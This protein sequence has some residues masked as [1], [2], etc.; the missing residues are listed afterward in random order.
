MFTMNKNKIILALFLFLM[1]ITLLPAQDNATGL[2]RQPDNLR[3]AL[4]MAQPNG[5]IKGEGQL[6]GDGQTPMALPGKVDLSQY[7]PR[8][9]TQ[10]SIGSCS[11]WSTVYYSKT[12]QENMERGWG[13]D[14]TD[15]MFNPMYTYNQIAQGRNEGT[16]IVDHMAM[17]VDQGCATIA[18]FPELYNLR[19]RPDQRAR[20]EAA[21]YKADS[22]ESLDVY[23]QATGKWNVD[24]NRVKTL[25]AAGYPVVVG[26]TL[27]ENFDNYQGGVY[28]R[29]QGGVTGGHAMCI[30]GYDDSIQAL[31]IVNSWGQDWGDNG[32]FYLSYNLFAE[33]A[34]WGAGVLYDHKTNTEQHAYPPAGL[35]ATQGTF[36][37]QIKLVWTAVT[38][39]KE[40]I[41][42]KSDNANGTLKEIARLKDAEFLDQPLPEGVHYI[43][44]VKSVSSSGK[45]S[46]FS[47]V[48][49]GWTGVSAAGN[50]PGIPG[51]LQFYFNGKAAVY[52]WDEV[53]NADGYYV[54]RWDAANE[55]WKIYGES[56]DGVF[57]DRKILK[58]KKEPVAYYIV[59]AWN[60]DGES[61]ATS[62]MTINTESPQ[63]VKPSAEKVVRSGSRDDRADYLKARTYE[64]DFYSPDYF[65]Y[66]YTMKQFQDFYEA[67]KKAFAEWK[68][69]EK[70]D[71]EAWK[72]KH[73]TV[74][75]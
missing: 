21:Q 37:G 2:E 57:L 50:E 28:N 56:R 19:A 12:M 45:V 74:P 46:D 54:Y 14:E 48:A 35:N 9:D 64:G 75:K 29:I 20:N 42:F 13:A 72:K 15:E 32:F 62:Y 67:E 44:S 61:Y 25:L 53:D 66:E 22:Y 70:D 31:K 34:Q 8:I 17:I 60:E 11:A 7:L 63:S 49:E 69:K 40:Y 18:T 33:L 38:G 51:N 24:L 71:F 47:P 3:R 10:G 52:F 23:D 27:Y 16:A 73:D 1:T 59:S 6:P 39:A 68:Q 30:V 65:D 36:T 43:Y 55:E 58:W 41:V 26:F 4:P 5:L